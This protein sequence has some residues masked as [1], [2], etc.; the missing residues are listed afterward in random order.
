MICPSCEYEYVKGVSN[1]PDCKIEL[2]SEDEFEGNLIHHADW[3]VVYTSSDAIE[4][5]M[6]KSNLA[7][8]NIEALIL[9]QKDSSYPAVGDLAVIKLLVKKDDAEDASAIINDI[10]RKADED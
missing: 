1:C 4:M 9:S 6:L 10:N 7:G 2:I 5:E 8:A 3:L